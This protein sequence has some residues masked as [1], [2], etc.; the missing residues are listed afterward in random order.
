MEECRTV[1]LRTK[2]KEK[3]ASA[4]GKY[5]V[6]FS[7]KNKLVSYA[8]NKI[9]RG[10]GKQE[11]HQ[12]P[13]E[14]YRNSHAFH[15]HLWGLNF[16][17]QGT[18][19][20]DKMKIITCIDVKRQIYISLNNSIFLVYSCSKRVKFSPAQKDNTRPTHHMSHQHRINRGLKLCREALGWL[21][22]SR[23]VNFTNEPNP[24][25]ILVSK[26]FAIISTEALF[27]E[28]GKN[29][30]G[31]E[32]ACVVLMKGCPWNWDNSK[33]REELQTSFD[34]KLHYKEYWSNWIS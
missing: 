25:S 18:K 8:L 22:H 21:A 24:T 6:C 20:E 16:I 19:I 11:N 10:N 7:P 14:F 31:N 27:Q 4:K 29:N 30:I 32:R 5:V 13:N 17:F 34:W 33:Q 2:N 15:K 1:S 3:G 23:E 12:Y 9:N 26:G 28:W